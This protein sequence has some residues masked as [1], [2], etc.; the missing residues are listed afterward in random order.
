ME[1]LATIAELENTLHYHKQ[2]IIYIMKEIKNIETKLKKTNNSNIAIVSGIVEESTSTPS[3]TS[4]VCMKQ[5]WDILSRT[6]DMTEEAP[7]ALII[8]EC[9]V[10]YADVLTE[11]SSSSSSSSQMTEVSV[12][13][14]I[15]ESGKF[16]LDIDTQVQKELLLSQGYKDITKN[17]YKLILELVDKYGLKDK[18][19]Y[20][21]VNNPNTAPYVPVPVTDNTAYKPIVQELHTLTLKDIH[22]ISKY[23]IIFFEKF[24]ELSECHKILERA[25]KVYVCIYC[26]YTCY[27]K[28]LYNR[29]R[30]R[31]YGS[32]LPVSH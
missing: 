26:I 10:E 32:Y 7:L 29:R 23:L 6:F 4:G 14:Y 25:E 30:R 19:Y 31:F 17:D 11:Q 2:I 3:T 24:I 1:S 15:L 9:I 13:N 8:K 16:E 28:C 18:G 5:T 22:Y 21:Y 20:E 27:M 12:L